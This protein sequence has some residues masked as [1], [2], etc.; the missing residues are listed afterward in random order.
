MS[1]DRCPSCAAVVRKDSDWCSLCYA[2]LR[3]ARLPVARAPYPQPSAPPAYAA[4]PGYAGP[5]APPAVQPAADALGA[6]YEHVLAA[7]Y[8][9]AG[10][11]T[12]Q[13]TIAPPTG[14]AP[15]ES[16][17]ETPANAGGWP[18]VQCSEINDFDR[19]SCAV[20]MAPFGGNLRTNRPSF[21]RKQIMIYAV[22]AAVAFLVLVGGLTFA[23]TKRPDVVPDNIPSQQS[24][25][26]VQDP[27]VEREPVEPVE[28]VEPSVVPGQ[29][30]SPDQPVAPSGTATS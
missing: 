6:P 15:A 28:T 8:G 27:A 4:P 17:A 19:M 1:S 14:A 22:A 9:G 30:V 7:V 18:C 24:E 12:A 29:P 2:D 16:T 5:P 20:C 25:N 26:V 21:D 11:M 10:A 23:T 13:A 3:P